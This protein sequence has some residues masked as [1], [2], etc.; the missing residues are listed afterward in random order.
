MNIQDYGYTGLCP[1]P[2]IGDGQIARVLAVHRDRFDIVCDGGSGSATL[3]RSEYI[4]GA[5]HYPTTG[6]FVLIDW[7]SQNG[8]RITK[9]LERRSFFSRRNPDPTRP[10]EQ[11]VAANFDYVFIIQ[12]L[13]HDFNL[14]RMERYITL[15]WQS[16]AQPVVVL[17]KADLMP[18]AAEQLSLLGSVAPGIDVAVVSA[19]SG[20]G[21]DSIEK[22]FAPRKTVVFLGSSGVGKSSLLNA[23]A[24]KEIMEV[25]A[26]R[27]D[28]SKGRH[29]AT[30][31]QLTMLPAGAMV[32]DT[33]GMRELG[34]WDVSEGMS[35]GFPDV[36]QYAGLCKFSDCG[37]GGEPGCAIRAAID[38][39]ELDPKRFDSYQKL[40]KEARFSEDNAA[41]RREKTEFHKS[42]AK[43]GKAQK[44]AGKIRK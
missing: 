43:F 14:R 41:Y 16:G 22:Y 21:M 10:R 40:K 34:M 12:S 36:E 2:S 5:Q 33:P 44:K 17:T 39:G 11:A 4:L 30:Y 24:G 28:D 15:G 26:I 42:L 27:E 8:S 19:H 18:D 37:H 20:L 23:L 29:A 35:G 6:D 38:L 31:R 7:H 9:T 13:N 3:K 25:N 32:I 1:D